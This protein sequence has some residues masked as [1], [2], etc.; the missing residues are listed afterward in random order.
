MLNK[1]MVISSAKSF[2]QFLQEVCDI[3]FTTG[4]KIMQ[5]AGTPMQEVVKNRATACGF[6]QACNSGYAAAQ[7]IIGYAVVKLEGRIREL[8]RLAAE[9]RRDRRPGVPFINGRIAVFKRRQQ[10]LRRVVDGILYAKLG[11]QPWAIKRLLIADELT[12]IDPTTLRRMLSLA[13]DLNKE[14][15]LSLFI[16]SDLTTCV[17]VGDLVQFQDVPLGVGRWNLVEVKEGK[18]NHMLLSQ[19]LERRPSSCCQPL[20]AKAAK[21]KQRIERQFGRMNNLDSIFRTDRGKDFMT[22]DNLTMTEPPAEVTDYADALHRVVERATQGRI[23]GEV[24]D[25]CLGIL[26]LKRNVFSLAFGTNEHAFYHF[27]HP[28]RACTFGAA[29][30]RNEVQEMQRMPRPQNLVEVSLHTPWALPVFLWPV[31]RQS[32]MDLVMRRTVVLANFDYAAWFSIVQQQGFKLRWLKKHKPAK[33]DYLP[34]C[35]AWGIRVQMPDG[36]VQ[37]VLSGLFMR[38]FC[39]LTAP[40]ALLKLIKVMPSAAT[41][42]VGAEKEAAVAS[43]VGSVDVD[44]PDSR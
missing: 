17:Q 25:G 24:V 15:R 28:E 32:M 13:Q 11:H 18:L 9:K 35:S 5:A 16:I 8:E 36:I 34:G 27:W 12:R 42:K 31:S 44:R 40:N 2:E 23:G 19:V 21:Q 14:D 6:L 41:P 38:V 26:A 3:A 20:P 29:D 4:A 7:S 10:I 33:Y 30:E 39:Y 22:G 43:E 1:A 37:D